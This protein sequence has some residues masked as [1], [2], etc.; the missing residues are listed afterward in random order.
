MRLILSIIVTFIVIISFQVIPVNAASYDYGNHGHWWWCDSF[1]NKDT[2]YVG[3]RGHING[4][5]GFAWGN[6]GNLYNLDEP[7]LID[8]HTKISL[9]A[10]LCAQAQFLWAAAGLEVWIIIWEE[11]AEN[12]G[13]YSLEWKECVHSKWIIISGQYTYLNRIL[14]L[15]SSP[16]MEFNRSI[17]IWVE[18]E[19]FTHDIFGWVHKPGDSEECAYMR[20]YYIYYTEQ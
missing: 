13:F 10:Y 20:T 9:T 17:I 6:V 19:V 18:L 11:V 3:A 1:S 15:S 16:T 12:P 4:G 14:Y 2:G 5:S 7:T 8:V